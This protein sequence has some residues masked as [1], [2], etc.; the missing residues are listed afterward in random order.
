MANSSAETAVREYLV[1]LKDPSALRDDSTLTDLRTQLDEATDTISRLELRQRIMD[2]ESP[3]LQ[4]YEEAFVTHAKAWADE[5]QITVKAFAAEGVQP[6]VLRRAGFAVAGRARGIGRSS[7]RTGPARTRVTTQEVRSGIGKKP[8]TV[9]QLQE[10]S[11]ASPAV[12]RKVVQDE[13]AEGRLT[14][15]GKDPDHRGPGR[16]PVLYKRAG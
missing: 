14:E 2:V 9:K 5:R 11:G 12:V 8:F 7:S 1:A 16:A 15:A 4:R 6:S 10:S 3:S 13:L